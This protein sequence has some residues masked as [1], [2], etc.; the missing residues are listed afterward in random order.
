ML[1]VCLQVMKVKEG[2]FHQSSLIAMVSLLKP[3]PKQKRVRFK[4]YSKGYVNNNKFRLILLLLILLGGDVERHPGPVSLEQF[5]GM[6]KG[7]R[8]KIPK[9]EMEQ[10]LN[11]LV[12]REHT[13]EEATNNDVMAELRT[14]KEDLQEIK[15]LKT[16]VEGQGSKILELEKEVNVLKDT[17]TAQ[18]RFWEEIEGEKR[19]KKL[20][21]LGIKEEEGI[22]DS[23][24]I[25]EVLQHLQI[26]DEIDIEE[27]KRLGRRREAENDEEIVH[28][29]PI[30]VT[31]KEKGMRNK[32]LKNARKL[33]DT[34]EGSWMKTVFIKAD[35]HPEVRKEMKRLNDIARQERDKPEN[36]GVE[37]KF[38]RRA[39]KITRN[40]ET[41][42][43][44]RLISLFQ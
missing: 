5:K 25:T 16:T 27:S 44:F 6:N 29:R 30:L 12:D 40:G 21:F 34:N 17:V 7:Q 14:I 10:L 35:E 4:R 37:I 1:A 3:R 36:T 39:R 18:Q 31:V 20:I 23:T 32:V 41:I 42:D 19:C 8:G 33:K 38:D 15:G 28:K 9:P 24:K 43:S 13:D 26:S 11:A 2:G 22:N